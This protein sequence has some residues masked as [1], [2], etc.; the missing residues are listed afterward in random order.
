MT[1]LLNE[2]Q[3]EYVLYHLN[4][5]VKTLGSV[6]ERF[7]F[8]SDQ[9]ASEADHVG[10]VIFKLSPHPI[11][12]SFKV[13]EIPVLFPLSDK[14]SFYEIDT[15][16][17]LIF[18]HDILKCVFY[19][20]SGYQEYAN[21]SSKDALSRFSFTDSIQHKLGCTAKPIVNYYFQSIV[22]ALE[23][24]CAKNQIT[25][26]RE[27]LF[28]NFGFQLS[29]D[30][31][32]V[33]LYTYNYVVYKIK[34]IVG[35]RKSKL[36]F[37]LNS[38][39][40]VKGLL[41]YAGIS[42]RDNPHWNFDYL[43][44]LEDRHRLKSIFFFLDQGV[45]N[46][47]A[48][49]AFEEQRIVDLFST[50]KAGGHEIGF[51]GPVRSVTDAEIMKTSLKRLEA[52]AGSSIKGSR[53]HRLLWKHPETAKIQQQNGFRYDST[54]G[55]AAH[56]GFRN[57][58][59]YPFKLYDFEADRIINMWEVPLMVMDSTLFSYQRYSVAK[60]FSACEGLV[61][62]VQKF[63]GVFTLLWHNSFFDED[64]YPG[65]TKF[66]ETLLQRISEKEPENILGLELCKRMDKLPS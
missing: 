53:Q 33:D 58:Y 57:S 41:K 4:H 19:L 20:L 61:E 66:Y 2:A 22:E 63:G 7:V 25:F 49:H 46:S 26:Q 39:L 3:I 18:Q 48:A 35:L 42:K 31:D 17:S 45:K 38:K 12:Q 30:I 8:L 13:G 10:K 47:D 60:A 24:F 62:E 14:K 32:V 23:I 43:L 64:T 9:S 56:E 52:A 21:Q 28:E 11:N 16:G 6:R 54:L 50:L 37:G 36:S 1:G 59:C 44:R 65:V 27:K 34:E 29:H 15:K 55:F 40:F 51:H 5:H